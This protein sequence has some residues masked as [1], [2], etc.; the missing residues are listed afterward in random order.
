MVP[1]AKKEH[2][3]WEVR[4]RGKLRKE[5][6][7]VRKR[8]RLSK[9]AVWYWYLNGA[10]AFSGFLLHYSE[11]LRP[12]HNS[13]EG[14][15]ELKMEKKQICGS[16]SW[17]WLPPTERVEFIVSVDAWF[18]VIYCLLLLFLKLFSYFILRDGCEKNSFFSFETSLY[19]N[20]PVTATVLCQSLSG[21]CLWMKSQETCPISPSYWK[22][23]TCQ[24]YCAPL[25][26]HECVYY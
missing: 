7:E 20:L 18:L 17:F 12:Y 23:F 11:Q 9:G 10:A 26:T 16:D 5:D 3:F 14:K 19:L 22:S 4:L 21:R 2:I 13:F 1:V 15:I 24:R 6:W 25:F 8:G